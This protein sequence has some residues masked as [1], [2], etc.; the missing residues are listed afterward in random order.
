[1]EI[2]NMLSRRTILGRAAGTL[3]VVGIGPLVKVAKAVAAKPVPLPTD[4]FWDHVGAAEY[5]EMVRQI[6]S[7]VP[8][9]KSEAIIKLARNMFDWHREQFPD[10]PASRS[11]IT[12]YTVYKT[13][14]SVRKLHFSVAPG[15]VR[16]W[17]EHAA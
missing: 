5:A 14:G 12:G 16:V 15:D 1:V 11:P 4:R 13:D 6:R 7:L 17:T 9:D 8:A 10:A 3:A 2:T